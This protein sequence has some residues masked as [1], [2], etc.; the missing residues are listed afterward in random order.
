LSE[1][2]TGEGM[3]KRSG[4]LDAY[5]G[6]W[7]CSV[8]YRPVVRYALNNERGFAINIKADHAMDNYF[9]PVNIIVTDG[10]IEL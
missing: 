10:R 7:T 3:S 1:K 4:L 2:S 6:S 5:Q 9:N 8:K